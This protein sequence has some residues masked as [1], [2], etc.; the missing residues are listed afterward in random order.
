MKSNGM[1]SIARHGIATVPECLCFTLSQDVDTL[2]SG[3]ETV[4]Q[5][6]QNVAVVKSMRKMTA[7]EIDAVLARTAKGPTGPKVEGYKR[8]DAA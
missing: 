4:E 2:V 7:G 3:V 8:K 5:L 1:G 6:E